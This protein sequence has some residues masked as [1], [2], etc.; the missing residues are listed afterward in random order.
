M[1]FRGV[2]S[3]VVSTVREKIRRVRDAVSRSSHPAEKPAGPGSGAVHVSAEGIGHARGTATAIAEITRSGDVGAVVAA[4]AA[5]MVAD[6]VRRALQPIS[7]SGTLA[8]SIEWRIE[9]DGNA[10][11]YSTAPYAAAILSPGAIE[12]GSPSVE[13]LMDWMNYKEEFSGLDANEKRR[14]AFAI[15]NAIIARRGPGA[16]SDLGRLNPTGQ[17]AYDYVNEALENVGPLLSDA[18]LA[19]TRLL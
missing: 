17:R 14:V 7:R 5:Q 6:Q 16:G 19:V 9:P 13:A 12:S 4:E 18:G 10:I 8:D 3:S 15:R 2:L 11:V 1:G